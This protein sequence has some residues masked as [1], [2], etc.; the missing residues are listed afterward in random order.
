MEPKKMVVDINK[1]E[2]VEVD[3][4]NW[5]GETTR[6][7]VIPEHIFF[8]SAQWDLED[9]WF[10]NVYDLE[11]D[12]YRDIAMKDIISWSPKKG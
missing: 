6:S 3:Y 4:T 2:I 1:D 12:A 9:Q 5:R 8:G 11:W 10:L 7:K